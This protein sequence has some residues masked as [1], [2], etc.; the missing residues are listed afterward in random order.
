MARRADAARRLARALRRPQRVGGKHA[1]GHF[2]IALPEDTVGY[3]SQ[4]VS[5]VGGTADV[6]VS[7]GADLHVFGWADIA[8]SDTP[9]FD[10]VSRQPV[11]SAAPIGMLLDL[12]LAD[13]NGKHLIRV[14][15]RR[16]VR[17]SDGERL[18]AP[19]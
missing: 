9:F 11:D 2:V 8:E 13:P 5:E 14:E 7:L 18:L 15:E 10:E 3:V 17:L 16:G 6:V 1:L 4:R 19:A 12:V